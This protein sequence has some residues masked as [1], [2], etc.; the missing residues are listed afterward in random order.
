[1]R[2]KG[3]CT[4]GQLDCAGREICGPSDGTIGEC[5]CDRFLGFTGPSCDEPTAVTFFLSGSLI[6]VVVSAIFIVM[7]SSTMHE[8]SCSR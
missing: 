3:A 6:V 7:V 1:M 8:A 5:R 2:V 4:Y